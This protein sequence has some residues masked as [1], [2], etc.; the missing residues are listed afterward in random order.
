MFSA[1]VLVRYQQSDEMKITEHFI[2]DGFARSVNY[3]VNPVYY[4]EPF[5]IIYRHHRTG[6]PLF[7]WVVD[8]KRYALISAYVLNKVYII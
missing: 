7:N 4:E 1:H 5:S 2:P 3:H 6:F 8:R